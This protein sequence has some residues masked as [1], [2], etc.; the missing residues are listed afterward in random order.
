MARCREER[1]ELIM[2][3]CKGKREALA[4]DIGR[5]VDQTHADGLVLT[6]PLSASR[7]L[8]DTLDAR[9]LPFVRIAPNKMRHPSPYVDIDD[10]AGAQEMTEYLIGLG[11]QRI[12]FIIGNPDHYASGRRLDGYKAAL[13]K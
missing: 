8:I 7:E 12:D 1:F 5:L 9:S 3:H 2:H 11:H 13:A 6:P 10:Q 4:E